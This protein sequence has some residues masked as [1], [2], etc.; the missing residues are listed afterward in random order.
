M[1]MSQARHKDKPRGDNGAVNGVKRIK[2]ETYGLKE[3][4]GLLQKVAVLDP[5]LDPK[6]PLPPGWLRQGNGSIRMTK[7]VFSIPSSGETCILPLGTVRLKSGSFVLPEGA[8]R[9]RDANAVK[10]RLPDGS[11]F[12]LP[13]GQGA[14]LKKDG[15]IKLPE[16]ATPNL[17]KKFASLVQIFTGTTPGQDPALLTDQSPRSVSEASSMVVDEDVKDG[18]GPMEASPA[19]ET[20]FSDG[21]VFSDAEPGDEASNQEGKLE[22][23]ARMPAI[24]EGARVLPGGHV[25]LPRTPF[26]LPDRSLFQL[27]H[28]STAM[29]DGSFQL[30]AGSVRQ[31]AGSAFI[32]PDGSTFKPPSSVAVRENGTLVLPIGSTC[33]FKIPYPPPQNNASAGDPDKLPPGFSQLADGRILMPAVAFI[34]PDHTEFR[35]PLGSTML[36]DGTFRLPDGSMKQKGL[37]FR[38]PDGTSF[39]LPKN[40]LISV[41]QDASLVIPLSAKPL[42]RMPVPR[43]K[44]GTAYPLP[45]GGLRLPRTAYKLPN[46]ATVDM[47]HGTVLMPDESIRLP[48]GS[49]KLRGAEFMLPNNTVFPI[50]EDVAVQA[51]GSLVLPSGSTLADADAIPDWLSLTSLPPGFEE[52]PGGALV[53]PNMQYRAPDGSTVDIPAGTVRTVTGGG[54]GGGTP[55]TPRSPVPGRKS[56]GVVADMEPLSLSGGSVPFPIHKTQTVKL[57]DGSTF[58]AL[59]PSNWA[60]VPIERFRLPAHCVQ[61]E[62]SSYRLP[63][64]RAFTPPPGSHPLTNESFRLPEGTLPLADKR[65]F[66]MPDGSVLELPEDTEAKI[67]REFLKFRLPSDCH[68]LPLASYQLPNGLVF[69]PPH[70]SNILHGG[71]FKG[72]VYF[73][74]PEGSER[75]PEGASLMPDG[76]IFTLPRVC[77]PLRDGSFQLPRGSTMLKEGTYRLPDGKPWTPPMSA[78]LLPESARLGYPCFKLPR[79]T[80]RMT[81]RSFKLPTGALYKLP[82]NAA[83]L[84]EDSFRLPDRSAL[85]KKGSYLLPDGSI[86]SL[87]PG[88]VMLPNDEFR[89]PLGVRKLPRGSCR[90]PDSALAPHVLASGGGHASGGGPSGAE[91]QWTVGGGTGND[92]GGGDG[93]APDESASNSEADGAPGAASVVPP[94]SPRVGFENAIRSLFIPPFGVAVVPGEKQDM[95]SIPEGSVRIP[96][97]V[98][99]CRNGELFH[100]PDNAILGPN[101]S[102]RVPRTLAGADASGKHL[103]EK[104]PAHSV[105]LPSGRPFTLPD[106]A[107]PMPSQSFRMGVVS[108]PRGSTRLPEWS[109]MSAEGQVLFV[110]PEGGRMLSG[111]DRSF[112]LPGGSYPLQVLPG[113]LP[114]DYLLLPD[115]GVRLPRTRVQLPLGAVAGAGMSVVFPLGTV[116][117]PDGTFK[118]PEGTTR[119]RGEQFM[120]PDNSLFTLPVPLTAADQGGPAVLEDGSIFLGATGLVLKPV[121][122]DEEV[123]PDTD[124]TTQGV[125]TDDDDGGSS[126]YSSTLHE[127]V[128]A[129]EATPSKAEG[130]D[131]DDGGY[132]GGGSEDGGSPRSLER[133]SNRSTPERR[134]AMAHQLRQAG[135]PAKGSKRDSR[136]GV[137]AASG[138]GQQAA[139]SQPEVDMQEAHNGD[140]NVRS[141]QGPG[142]VDGAIQGHM[143]AA[144]RDNETVGEDDSQDALLAALGGASRALPAGDLAFIP[145]SHSGSRD[146]ATTG[147]KPSL[148]TEE[149]EHAAAKKRR[150]A[151]LEAE[152]AALRPTPVRSASG[153]IWSLI[154]R[155]CAYTDMGSQTVEGGGLGLDLPLSAATGHESPALGKQAAAAPARAKGGRPR[156]VGPDGLGDDGSKGASSSA[157]GVAGARAGGGIPDGAPGSRDHSSSD[158]SLGVARTLVYEHGRSFASQAG[159]S[160]LADA[161]ASSAGVSSSSVPLPVRQGTARVGSGPRAESAHGVTA[162]SSGVSVGVGSSDMDSADI[163][164]NRGSGGSTIATFQQSRFVP[165]ASAS[166]GTAD[167][168][169]GMPG[170]SVVLPDIVES[171]A[172]DSSSYQSA[173]QELST[174]GDL[175]NEDHEGVGDRA[176]DSKVVIAAGL[177]IQEGE[178]GEEEEEEMAK[179]AAGDAVQLD[180]LWT[181]SAMSTYSNDAYVDTEDMEAA[182]DV[183]RERGRA[184]GGKDV[185]EWVP[186]E[187]AAVASD[188]GGTAS[189]AK[190][191]AKVGTGLTGFTRES[192]EKD[193]K[194]RADGIAGSEDEDMRGDASAG[195]SSKGEPGV[196]PRSSLSSSSS[197]A[198]STSSTA[199]SSTSEGQGEALAAVEGTEAERELSVDQLG[200]GTHEGKG[201]QAMDVSD[202]NDEDN[203][204]GGLQLQVSHAQGSW[205]TVGLA[206]LPPAQGAQEPPSADEARAH[207]FRMHAGGSSTVSTET[208]GGHMTEDSGVQTM[209]VATRDEAL[210]AAL[211]P[212]MPATMM[213]DAACQM[214][215]TAASKAEKFDEEEEEEEEDAV[216]PVGDEE[217]VV[218]DASLDPR[219][220][221]APAF[222]PRVV[223]SAASGLSVMTTATDGASNDWTTVELPPPALPGAALT[224]LPLPGL[225]VSLDKGSPSRVL[226]QASCTGT[227]AE[228]YLLDAGPGGGDQSGSE[229]G[230]PAPLPGATA[231]APVLP[232]RLEQVTAPVIRAPSVVGDAAAAMAVRVAPVGQLGAGEGGSPATG[233]PGTENDEI[234]DSDSDAA[235]DDVT[236]N[237]P[238]ADEGQLLAAQQEHAGPSGLPSTSMTTEKGRPPPA[239]AVRDGSISTEPQASSLHHPR[240]VEMPAAPEGTSAGGEITRNLVSSLVGDDTPRMRASTGRASP[241]RRLII[242]PRSSGVTKLLSVA[243]AAVDAAASTVENVDG[244]S[245]S[246][247]NAGGDDM[248]VA[249]GLAGAYGFNGDSN[250]AVVASS[251]HSAPPAQAVALSSHASDATAGVAGGEITRKLLSSLMGGVV[252]TVPDKPASWRESPPSTDRGSELAAAV[253][254][255]QTA[256]SATMEHTLADAFSLAEDAGVAALAVL[257]DGRW[258]VDGEVKAK[259]TEEEKYGEGQEEGV[260]MRT[261]SAAVSLVI[262]VVTTAVGTAWWEDKPFAAAVAGA[263]AGGDAPRSLP[264]SLTT[265]LLRYGAGGIEVP[266]ATVR[267]LDLRGTDPASGGDVSGGGKERDEK[268]VDDNGSDS[269]YAQ[270]DDSVD[271]SEGMSTAHRVAPACAPGAAARALGSDAASSEEAVARSAGVRGG[272]A[273]G[274]SKGRGMDACDWPPA[275]HLGSVR[276]GEEEEEVTSARQTG[277]KPAPDPEG[278]GNDAALEEQQ[279][280]VASQAESDQPCERSGILVP[281]GPMGWVVLGV[282]IATLLA[283]RKVGQ[284]RGKRMVCKT[285]R[286]PFRVSALIPAGMAWQ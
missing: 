237:V 108:L 112:L 101:L 185:P 245:G 54:G 30:P 143:D 129:H 153:A 203:E 174:A 207:A 273:D 49:V 235:G 107:E 118:L 159:L 234:S 63:D 89:L 270:V 96:K 33:P 52:L 208:D 83:T 152:M 261:A 217:R 146:A 7:T 78:K 264:G 41:L 239:G 231:N 69:M 168:A 103:I 166:S 61:V 123:E 252:T 278:G 176:R 120:L 145:E 22:G 238:E 197:S 85:V 65:A 184:A 192:P 243:V 24:L 230:S 105:R 94:L 189:V 3:G 130:G 164:H 204:Q 188:S 66:A 100:P 186:T 80:R 232:V 92:D 220:G 82:K 34:L 249:I 142:V 135:S 265:G 84:S 43:E 182:T 190:G 26:T 175:D 12:T 48:E 2:V 272:E 121:Y 277:G 88:S 111:K 268:K 196:R 183:A 71:Q 271:K 158:A 236:F 281:R 138:P 68:W 58:L 114:P 132:H 193:G 90:L 133:A 32:L 6:L 215:A 1:K 50:P 99:L 8:V 125:A 266:R 248:L 16:D 106:G 241:P 19:M 170:S 251:S 77:V 62:P 167:A 60:G 35:L 67:G 87:P 98:Y 233:L 141:A 254:G 75:L 269:V 117:Q 115:G 64:G 222:A 70:G 216:I 93:G 256:V 219:R 102:F 4:P 191:A 74:L 283:M 244:G 195:G 131:V 29:A 40:G 214:T 212:V 165:H 223:R 56:V 156:S 242:S 11:I 148:S 246:Q 210:Q 172:G 224:S 218:L 9:L 279:E 227:N 109:F 45:G 267:A 44:P 128:S 5:L 147:S 202:D 122:E 113:T 127:S 274:A 25:R 171:A 20:C 27:P 42:Q 21:E 18:P 253:E 28:G 55:L 200:G 144:S 260:D 136:A 206:K 180:E 57:P 225:R 95:Y 280:E 209:D 36:W 15:S 149:S 181:G 116:R 155:K 282:G 161:D 38:L 162:G 91:D 37:Q 51:D 211:S 163:G 10:F 229:P 178:E 257:A 86:F 173:V 247:D 157:S 194:D 154:P 119:L 139:G 17:P 126:V 47:P 221:I 81:L 262:P 169:V 226:L 199:S 213:A 285:K 228:S 284:G 201:V 151:E 79:G 110:L 97:G 275:P 39:A 263:S 14:M 259:E 286:R 134:R 276:F 205:A 198:S 46:G 179:A 255:A 250:G 59:R 13:R 187:K 140:Y 240:G 124:A 150:V 31:E 73:T 23:Q 160:D 258:A 177:T 137:D 76:S 104:L 72:A 53:L